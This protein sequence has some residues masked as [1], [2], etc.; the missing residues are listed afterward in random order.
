MPNAPLTPAQRRRLL[1]RRFA[2]RKTLVRHPVSLTRERI[3]LILL[4][5]LL[6]SLAWYACTTRDAAIRQRALQYLTEATTGEISIGGAHFEMF[7]GITLQNVRVAV[8]FDKRLDPAA[9]RASL[10]E[11]FFAQSVR[12][13]HDPWRLLLGDLRVDQ[14]IATGPTIIL[15]QNVET[16]LR[17]WQLLSPGR[18]TPRGAGR[19][20]LRPR[21]TIRS[22]KAVVVSI[23]ESGTHETRIEELDADVRPHPQADSAYCIEVRRYSDPPERTTVIFDPGQRLVTNTPFVDARTIR[24]QLPKPAQR[25]FDRIALQGEVKL[26]RLVYDA[27]PRQQKSTSIEL[28]SVRCAVPLSM[29]RASSSPSTRAP[30][31]SAPVDG[32]QAVVTMTDAQ[33]RLDLRGNRLELD[34]S[35]LINGAK[36]RVSGTLDRVGGPLHEMGLDLRIEGAGVP[37]PEDALRRQLL[38]DPGVPFLLRTI[39]ADYEPH[40]R[41]DL[42]FRLVRSPD[43]GAESQFSG[44]L[45]PIMATGRSR[46]FPYLVTDLSGQ[47]R[48]E[49]TSV[50]IE[51]LKGR[52]G[53][54]SIEI[55]GTV[56]RSSWWAGVDVNIAGR[57]IPLDEQLHEPLSERYR[58]L[59]ERFNP[60][61]T[62]EVSVQLRR[63]SAGQEVP[64]AQWANVITAEL[65]DAKIVSTEYPYPLEG[66]EGRLEISPDRVRFINL[67]GHNGDARARLDGEV[68]FDAA[69]RPGVSLQIQ[70]DHL[71]LDETL[72]SALPPDGRAAFAQFQPD[73]VADL[74]GTISQSGPGEAVVYD[75]TADISGASL[76]YHDFPY[77]LTDVSGRVAI[78]PE[79]ITVLTASGRHGAA[80]LS[81]R[82]E[83][84][85]DAAGYAANLFFDWSRLVL[86]QELHDALPGPLREVWQ[87]LAPSGSVNVSTALHYSS[88]DQSQRPRHRTEIEPVDAA[89]CFKAFPLPLKL[90]GGKAL[91]ADDTVE[92]VSL[93][94]LAGGGSFVLDG[95]LDFAPP[96]ARG[97][98]TISAS[99]MGFTQELV[100]SMPPKLR[101]ALESMSPRGQF[102]LRLDPLR[103]EAVSKDAAADWRFAGQLTLRGA[104]TEG[105]LEMRDAT[106]SL[107][108]EGRVDAAGTISLDANV[109]LARAVLAGWPLDQLVARLS[110]SPGAP[111]LQVTDASAQLYGG[112]A[113][114][115]AEIRFSDHRT[116]YDL[117]VTAREL[118]LNRYIEGTRSSSQATSRPSSTAAEGL[119]YGNVAVKGRTGFGGYREGTG[120]VFLRD[121]QVW[122]LPIV[123][124]VFQVMNLA[125]D[126]HVFHDGWVKYYL[127][128]DTLTFHR[129]DLQGK[130]MSF[131]GGGRMDLRSKALDVKLLA[132]SPVRVQVPLLTELLEGASREVMEV[133]VDGTLQHPKITPRPLRGLTTVL[134][135]L[136]PEPPPVRSSEQRR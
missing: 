7:G 62:A 92:F 43:L 96:G 47:L 129:I 65:S 136:F 23:D 10:R 29:L 89:V 52:H 127:A 128:D 49:G 107:T 132:G 118:Q 66:V 77:R 70:A 50:F 17:N 4:V 86:D 51:E 105:G 36:C 83:I 72:A 135:T 30:A 90:S 14:I 60:E 67:N 102:D 12:L 40:G 124:A 80:E 22:A 31:A 34:V 119:I 57:M 94:G 111:V 121:A 71:K 76:L 101:H 9:Q 93:S 87:L 130:A 75:L 11:I 1:W 117:A 41:F 6:S 131:I 44:T 120:E 85:R 78:R 27:D 114:G 84:R 100:A 58:L 109:Q 104:A 42:S 95:Q 74:Y 64:D 99:G 59:W 20:N 106:G 112:E 98:L 19:G 81:A 122:K 56:D 133:Q 108:G 82:G 115:M 123:F 28:K 8:P 13:I 33:G 73:G 15:A 3:G 134:K 61:G 125:P 5:A 26:S 110:A 25:F 45:R 88:P 103:F 53:P 24:L 68:T 116:D 63:S 21:I 126:E 35:G 79:A 37:A 39:L 16:G 48:F 55:N 91:I 38:T 46:H 113:A 54:A 69:G 18:K 2:E 32:E 97:A